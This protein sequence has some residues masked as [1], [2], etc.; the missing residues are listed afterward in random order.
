VHRAACAK[1]GIYTGQRVQSRLPEHDRDIDMAGLRDH[2]DPLAALQLD[3]ID[4]VAVVPVVGRGPHAETPLPDGGSER[5]V[6]VGLEAVANGEPRASQRVDC[7]GDVEL[8]PAAER[9]PP[10]QAV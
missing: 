7:R 1:R 6:V 5:D 10:G 4:I 2:A 8:P 9:V 3:S